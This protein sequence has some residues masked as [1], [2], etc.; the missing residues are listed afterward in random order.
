MSTI[1]FDLDGTLINSAP[2]ITKSFKYAMQKM[3]LIAPDAKDLGWVIGPP[4]RKSFAKLLDGDEKKAEKAVSIYREFY[5]DKGIFDAHPYEGIRE[6]LEELSKNSYT[7]MICTAKAQPHAISVIKHFELDKYFKAI[8]G[9]GLDGSYDNK[10]DLLAK[11][12]KEQEINVG[13][14]CLIGDRVYDMVAADKNKVTPVGALW[15]F[16]SKKELLENGAKYT[17]LKPRELPQLIKNK[18]PKA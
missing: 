4:L 7:M 13:K 6:C 3:G 11:L 10:S 16:G 17:C 1:L 18:F 8:Y 2:G 15:G 12:I 5:A 14:S 9:P